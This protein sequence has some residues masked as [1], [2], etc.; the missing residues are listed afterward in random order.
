MS[1]TS[2]V[3]T[4]KFEEYRERFKE[5]YKLERRA[6]GVSLVRAHAKGRYS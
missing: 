6:D 3:P 5:H 4:P 2:F 1:L